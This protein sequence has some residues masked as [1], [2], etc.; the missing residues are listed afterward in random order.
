MREGAQ[1]HVLEKKGSNS[2]TLADGNYVYFCF[3]FFFLG[4]ID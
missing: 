4:M 3:I 2:E 1:K